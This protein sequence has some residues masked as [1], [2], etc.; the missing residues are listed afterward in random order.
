MS[1]IFSFGACF[2]P[3]SQSVRTGTAQHKARDKH[4]FKRAGRQRCIEKM[5]A[6]TGRN[7]YR[8]Q[9]TENKRKIDTG[10]DRQFV[11]VTKVAGVTGNE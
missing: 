1:G 10:R 6:D 5:Q 7:W 8:M 3:Y 2:G 9:E 4:T 11:T